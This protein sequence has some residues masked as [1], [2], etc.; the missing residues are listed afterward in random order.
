MNSE[1]IIDS[2]ASEVQIALLE[3]RRI[4]EFNSE[5]KDNSFS[6]GDIYLGRI[7]KIMPG[8]NAAFVDVG[9]DKDAFLH[10]LDLGPQYLS[11]MKFTKE[12]AAGGH[13]DGL[14]NG[15]SLEKD[16]EKG[17][18]VNGVLAA[19]QWIPVQIAKEPI[20]TKGPRITCDLSMAGR[21]VV[22]VPFT[23]MVSVS[24]K[25]KSSEERNRL[26][27]I[28]ASIKPQNF[29]IIIRT[30]AEGKK[31]AEIDKDIRDLLSKWASFTE[32][33]RTAKPPQKLLGE[34]NRTSTILRDMLNA[35]FSSIVVN[36][37]M[38][39]DEVRSYIRSIAP[40]QEEIVKFHK[41][42]VPVFEHYGID[43]QIKSVFGKTVNMQ[44]GAYLIVEHT[45]ALH[46]I[47]VNSGGR[48]KAGSDQENNALQV[49]MMAAK[50]IARQ[51]RLR[52]MGGI[53]VIDFI[54]MH[55]QQHRKE[56]FECVRN[57]MKRDRAKHTILPPSKFGL[58]Q[59]TRQRVRPETKIVT[60]E[61]CPSCNGTGEIKASILISDDIK[62]NVRYIL[63]EQNEPTVTIRV[64]PFL[65]AYLTQG[66]FFSSLRHKWQRE[67]KKKIQV[68]AV[69]SYQMMEYHY[70]GRNGEEILL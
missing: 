22:M 24:Q 50:E 15:F 60:A 4:V 18:K 13:R 34:M 6:V 7:R 56:L 32:L 57:E 51:L 5:K 45:E 23:N 29:G 59:I 64:H 58:I 33:L 44:N 27:R 53:I 42:K 12:V 17:G 1:L 38:V 26:K 10:Y 55:S 47:D 63:I 16:L 31:T 66:L 70:F 43:K 49:N 28:V 52:D 67:F 11:L 2:S 41:G 68:E 65:A 61:K 19:N 48:S 30:V 8:L 9:H 39:F 21:F 20:S 46:V 62:S 54:D 40:E 25:I 3:D 35:G 69:S 14:L 37:Q 36:D